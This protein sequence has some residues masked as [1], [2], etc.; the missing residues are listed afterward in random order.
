VERQT[1]TGT[2]RIVYSTGPLSVEAERDGGTSMSLRRKPRGRHTTRSFVLVRDLNSR[3]F[4]TRHTHT[5]QGFVPL[6]F[7]SIQLK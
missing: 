1:E 3:Q 6:I 5:E 4:G 2:E 7:L